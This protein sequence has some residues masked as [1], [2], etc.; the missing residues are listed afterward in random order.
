MFSPFHF[1]KDHLEARVCDGTNLE[2]PDRSFDLAFSFSSIEHFGGH[3]QAVESLK[4]MFRV[5]KPGGIA[6]ITTELILNTLGRI[7]GFFKRHQLNRI[8]LASTGFRLAGGGIDLRIERRFLRDPI[9]F[10]FEDPT[11][12]CVVLRKGFATFTS[13]LLFLQ[14]PLHA[15]AGGEQAITG[16]ERPYPIRRYLH[17]ATITSPVTRSLAK[18][19]TAI[20]LPLSVRNAGDV[21]WYNH[22]GASHTVRI[23][24]HL[25]APDGSVLQQNFSRQDLPRSLR[26]GEEV[27]LD[28]VCTAPDRCGDFALEIDLVKEGV[29]WFGEE[30]SPTLTVGLR[31][32]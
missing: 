5:L 23:G 15:P 28:L 20:R 13:I 27:H 22:P 4:E 6:V 2:F 29:L 21:V 11:R 7:P 9:D 14:K 1:R 18:R 10:P 19:R 8:F 26:P 32:E 30:G 16:E 12:P 25:L 24:A 31:V 17:K 3:T